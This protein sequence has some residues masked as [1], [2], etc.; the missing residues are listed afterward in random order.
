MDPERSDGIR[1]YNN[2]LYLNFLRGERNYQCTAW[3]NPTY[4]IMGWRLPC[5][6]LADKHVGKMSEIMKPEVWEKLRRWK[7]P[8]VRQLHDALRLRVGDH[9][10]SRHQPQGL[11]YPHPLRGNQQE[12]H[13]RRLG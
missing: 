12:R 2:P 4:T 11:G 7:G 6:P 5:Y 13:N 9:L 3:S 1:F 8:Q 10:R